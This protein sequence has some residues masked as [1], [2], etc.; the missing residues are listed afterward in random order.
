MI[1][2]QLLPAI[3][4]HEQTPLTVTCSLLIMEGGMEKK[5]PAFTPSMATDGFPSNA[6]SNTFVAPQGK[7]ANQIISS[8]SVTS[9]SNGTSVP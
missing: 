8:R 4:K 3:P 2:C 5:Y 6:W 7:E 1:S 9:A